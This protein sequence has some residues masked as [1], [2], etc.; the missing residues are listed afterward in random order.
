MFEKLGYKKIVTFL[1]VMLLCV[2]L[3]LLSKLD[4]AFIELQ[5]A[6]IFPAG[7][8]NNTESIDYRDASA[9]RP[10]LLLLG[11][12]RVRLWPKDLFPEGYAVLN[13]A[14]GGQTSSQTLLQLYVDRIPSGDLAFVQT[15][16]NDI[17]P[18]NAFPEHGE[19]IVA[20]CMRNI[21]EIVRLLR[22][23]GYKLILSTILPPGNP[24]FH[25]LQY[26]PNNAD[27][28]IARVNNHINSL[29]SKDVVIFNAF[30]FLKENDSGRIK[31]EY[32][33]PDFFLHINRDAYSVLAR[34]LRKT[35]LEF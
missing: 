34:E 31:R 32:E 17:H 3:I 20:Q 21:E 26:W 16:I 33:D 10:K 22:G 4:S 29:R 27:Q 28:L 24:P 12:S 25:R 7:Y 14:N 11:D 23:K 6:R 2:V 19:L 13:R 9:S 8:I 15:C 30:D 1:I 5:Q 18:L 35:L